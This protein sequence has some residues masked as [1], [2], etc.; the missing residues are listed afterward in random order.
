MAKGLEPTDGKDLTIARDRNDRSVGTPVDAREAVDPAELAQVGGDDPE[1]AGEGL[2]GDE[3]IVGA[4]RGSGGAER[5][6]DLPGG[7]GVVRLER[8]NLQ[9]P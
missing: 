8:E 5:L 9:G 1:A 4:D 6:A 7:S 3:Q 2:T